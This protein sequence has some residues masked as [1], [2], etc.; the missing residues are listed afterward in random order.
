MAKGH[1]RELTDPFQAGPKSSVPAFLRKKRFILLLLTVIG[2]VWVYTARDDKGLGRAFSMTFSPQSLV[3]ASPHNSPSPT[4]LIIIAWAVIFLI[5]S[6]DIAPSVRTKEHELEDLLQFFVAA[7]DASLPVDIDPSVELNRKSLVTAATGRS[8]IVPPVVVFSKTYC[9]YSKRAKS[10]LSS[11]K[12]EPA[13]YVVEVD[14]RSDSDTVKALLV[15]LTGHGT[16]PNILVRRKSIGGSDDLARLHESG[17]LIPLL[18][19]AGLIKRPGNRERPR[20]LF[21]SCLL[22]PRL[23]SSLTVFLEFSFRRLGAFV[24]LTLLLDAIPFLEPRPSSFPMPSFALPSQSKPRLT[25]SATSLVSSLSKKHQRLSAVLLLFL[26]FAAFFSFLFGAQHDSKAF[27][28]YQRATGRQPTASY[29][30]SRAF[31]ETN[32]AVTPQQK[33]TASAEPLNLTPAMELGALVAFLTDRAAENA[34]PLT[35]DPQQQIPADVM[36]DFDTRSDFAQL[37]VDDLVQ[38]TWMRNPVVIFS[39]VHSPQGR[40]LKKIFA[41]YKLKPAPVIFDV[42]QREDAAV[43]E[44]VLYRL[45][46]ET[47][48]PIVLLGGRSIGSPSDITKLHDSGD[49]EQ[50]MKS[51]GVSI[52]PPKKKMAIPAPK[53]K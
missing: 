41:S 7:P 10:L 39:K 23:L 21:I 19:T 5:H 16:F 49:L 36:L 11:L 34:L 46:G 27:I 43:L 15:R 8:A 31:K 14:L 17:E 4:V 30:L 24:H 22:I 1:S 25:S 26:S 35:I 12:L 44:P 32:R 53:L 40:D 18:A 50:A 37:E 13:P 20:K 28:A 2:V 45:I 29:P 48:L 47:S 9:P 42:D 51:A 33:S 6:S 52:V 3:I 38:D